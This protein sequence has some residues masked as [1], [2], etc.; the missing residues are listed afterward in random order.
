[1]GEARRCRCIVIGLAVVMCAGAM[2]A[3]CQQDL[4]SELRAEARAEVAAAAKAEI[5]TETVPGKGKLKGR[6]VEQITAMLTTGEADYE[7]KYACALDDDG[8]RRLEMGGTLAQLGMSAPSPANWY[9]GGFIDVVLNGVGLVEVPA[10]VE[11]M[12]LAEGSAGVRF[13]WPHPA[14][15]VSASFRTFSFDPFLYV[16]VDLPEAEAREIRLLCY[17]NSFHKPRDRWIT[18][19]M[20][21][22]RNR[23]DLLQSIEPDERG[24][25]L[26]SDRAGDVVAVPVTGP[27][28]LVLLPE[29]VTDLELAMGQPERP[30][31]PA[32]QNYGVFT[33]LALEPETRRLCFALVDFLPMTWMQAKAKLAADTRQVQAKL[34]GLLDNR[35]QH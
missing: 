6:E 34:R 9:L 22:I 16:V 29:Q 35:Q 28:G 30:D 18:T 27:C 32:I 3:W 13:I 25:L 4:L 17:P 23:M 24:W 11:A 33:T 20:R 10:T 7:L 8:E 14:G 5:K 19:P 2:A 1:M 12:N 21:D 26:Y 31:W 15:T